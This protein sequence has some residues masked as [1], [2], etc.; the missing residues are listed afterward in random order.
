MLET[1]L[2]GIWH[3]FRLRKEV[4]AVSKTVNSWVHAQSNGN[5]FPVNNLS[6]LISLMG[7]MHSTYGHIYFSHCSISSSS[8]DLS[9]IDSTISKMESGTLLPVCQCFLLIS[10]MDLII[11]LSWSHMLWQYRTLWS[12]SS[13]TLTWGLEQLQ[14]KW[15][16]K[17]TLPI[18][19]L[20]SLTLDKSLHTSQMTED[21]DLMKHSTCS[22]NLCSPWQYKLHARLCQEKF[23]AVPLGQ[24]S[25]Y[26]M[27]RF[28]RVEN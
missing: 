2:K 12:L 23:S 6:V 7:N 19:P 4:S 16:R 27:L 17:T 13:G 14:K 3:A 9:Q 11:N 28:N 21:T 24:S 22:C 10:V 20:L 8:V 15:D 18:Y 5:C 1:I 25:S 26:F